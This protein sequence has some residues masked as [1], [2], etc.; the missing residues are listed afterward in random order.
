VRPERRA[1]RRTNLAAPE[2]LE[3]R[4]LMAASPLG[5]SLPELTITGSAGGKA[6]WG[7][8]LGIVAT[9]VNVGTSTI[10][11]PIAQAPGSST[12]ADAPESTV[13]VVITPR[14]SMAHA[15]TI[16]TFESPAVPQ[17]SIRQI[18]ETLTL[19]SRPAGFSGAGGKFFIHLIVNS[20]SSVVVASREGETS[21]PIAVHVARAALP[22]L[23]AT[24][25]FVPST[26]SPGDTIVPTI[27]ITNEGTAPTSQPVEVAL[28][29]STT[30][31]FTVGSSII[32]LYEITSSIPAASQVASG[33]VITAFATTTTLNN[34]FTFTG[35][36]VTLPVS[37]AKYYLG[38]VVDPYGQ[39]TQL[40]LPKN[41]FEQIMTVGPNTS[42]LPP[43]GVIST[44]NSN[45]FPLP[46]SGTFIGLNPT[47]AT[48]NAISGT[49]QTSTQQ[50][51]SSTIE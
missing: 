15:V 5:F 47:L 25:L 11:N 6:A 4:E 37:P 35:P 51:P 27:S 13:A 41:A 43:A 30:K 32:A 18:A 19:P 33:G 20:T 10:T 12:T 9:V 29:A 39:I 17:N 36:A 40:S 26:L 7:G 42:G 8:S 14:R 31:S 38:V 48:S 34:T 28:V 50:S 16:G 2:R 24:S 3:S 44:A 1:R 23:R 22:E 21:A 46:A 49:G 45:P